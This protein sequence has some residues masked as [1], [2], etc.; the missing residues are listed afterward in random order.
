MLSILL[1]LSLYHPS[2]SPLA[3]HRDES[4]I[5]FEFTSDERLPVDEIESFFNN[6]T[7]V[8]TVHY[9]FSV[10]VFEEME[11]HRFP[12]DRQFLQ[13]QMLCNF[14]DWR[15]LD[16]P[17]SDWKVPDRYAE[18]TCMVYLAPRMHTQYELFTPLVDLKAKSVSGENTRSSVLFGIRVQRYQSYFATNMVFPLFLITSLSLS[19]LLIPPSEIADRIATILTLLLT[20]VAFKFILASEL[21][22]MS[23]MTYIDKY[24]VFIYLV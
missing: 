20:T 17:L 10:D 22:P 7:K 4:K 24:L 11:L 13:M 5:S 8:V 1:S 14:E 19:A 3:P 12:Y 9:R 2:A 18:T 6:E 15:F 16:Q 21:P 23:Y